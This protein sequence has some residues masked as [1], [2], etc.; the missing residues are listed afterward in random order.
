M[1]KEYFILNTGKDIPWLAF[2][3]DT[4]LNGKDATTLVHI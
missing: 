4:A 3:T 1:T 2:G